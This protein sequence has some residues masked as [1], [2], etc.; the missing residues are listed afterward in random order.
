MGKYVMSKRENGDF[1]FNL[2]A[3]NGHVI[4]T[5]E[6]YSSKAGC[7]NGIESVKKNA[8]KPTMYE[9][10]KSKNDEKYFVIKAKNGKT[11]GVSQMY[12]SES[13][14]ENAIVSVMENAPQAEI[15]EA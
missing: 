5:S 10:K 11:V 8:L 4:L 7:I 1:Q 14:F 15:I 6:G 9:R 12:K 2:E 3:D 13:G